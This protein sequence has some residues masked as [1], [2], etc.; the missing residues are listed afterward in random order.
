MKGF[1]KKETDKKRRRAPLKAFVMKCLAVCLSFC[2][3][4]SGCASLSPEKASAL[5]DYDE[6]LLDEL[7]K[8]S[9]LL[10]YDEQLFDVLMWEGTAGNNTQ[11]QDA[12][13][14]CPPILTR[15]VKGTEADWA[16]ESLYEPIHWMMEHYYAT[17]ALPREDYPVIGKYCT[18]MDAPLLGVTAECAYERTGDERFHQYMLDMVS[19]CVKSTEEGGFV[20]KLSD[21]EWWPLEYA[22]ETVSERDAAFVSNGSFFGMVAIEMLKNLTEDPRLIELSEKTLTAYKNRANQFYYPDGSWTFYSL[23]DVK[24]PGSRVINTPGKLLIEIRSLDSLYRLTNQK[25]YKEECTKRIDIMN[26]LYPVY[27]LK[28]DDGGSEVMFLRAGAPHPM[29]IDVF[30][31]DLEILDAS[32]NVLA[33]SS[34]S[35]R[36]VNGAYMRFP[37]PE[38]AARYRWTAAGYFLTEAPLKQISENE[39]QLTELSGSWR[40][41]GDGFVEKSSDLLRIREDANKEL[42]AWAYFKLSKNI[43]YSLE[44]YLIIELENESDVTFSSVT[45][46][47]YDS[48]GEVLWRYSSPCPPGKSYQILHYTGF[49]D[50]K[51]PLGHTKG[52]S[53]GFV[54]VDMEPGAEALVKLKAVYLATSTAQVVDFLSQREFSGFWLEVS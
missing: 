50:H 18:S 24:E 38:N 17:G 3:L 33:T 46:R 26:A 2:F 30:Q 5:H 6:P 11:A 43:S 14:L 31:T 27:F 8:T 36:S 47:I 21:N 7:I 49:R 48:R 12:L 42:K 39:L 22:W 51:W 25:F 16:D 10:D 1:R 45:P 53:L 52:F 34:C 4:L 41:T 54:T 28:T 23:N 37:V 29:Q 44:S 40:G 13:R 19:Y 9:A 20:L 15:L 35:D 32:G